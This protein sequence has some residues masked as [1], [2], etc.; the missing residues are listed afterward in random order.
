[1]QLKQYSSDLS[2]KEWQVINKLIDV[3]RKSKWELKE[4][5]NGIFYL[6]KN[7]GSWKEPSRGLSIIEDVPKIMKENRD[8]KCFHHFNQY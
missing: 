7:V 3:Q 4:I 5:M 1:M 2:V 8:C 6:T